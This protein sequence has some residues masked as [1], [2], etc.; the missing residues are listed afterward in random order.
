MREFLDS[1]EVYNLVPGEL[2]KNEDDDQL[3]RDKPLPLDETEA[4]VPCGQQAGTITADGPDGIEAI[5]TIEE[6]LKQLQ[7]EVLRKLISHEHNRMVELASADPGDRTDPARRVVFG[8]ALMAYRRRGLFWP[9]IIDGYL[10]TYRMFPA[11][12]S[13]QE[14]N[15]VTGQHTNG[16]SQTMGDGRP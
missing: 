12:I 11:P 10:R 3:R 4:A 16:D 15:G 8:L 5:E 14:T 7:T 2:D 13:A 6:R 9:S 1:M